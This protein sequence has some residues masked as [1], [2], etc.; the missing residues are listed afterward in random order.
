PR[1]PN[2]KRAPSKGLPE[3]NGGDCAGASETT[4][5][6]FRRNRPT[7]RGRTAAETVDT[8]FERQASVDNLDL[9]Q[10]TQ[11]DNLAGITKPSGT[12]AAATA[13]AAALDA[14]AGIRVG[15]AQT[16]SLV[17]RAL[18]REPL[19]TPRC[20]PLNIAVLPPSTCAILSPSIGALL[21]RPPAPTTTIHDIPPSDADAP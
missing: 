4:G 20:S 10:S 1:P 12:R 15:R 2:Q 16:L 13:N 18:D 5:I 3:S 9:V 8:Q 17:L 21:P 11:C 14:R 19:A 7:G 6:R